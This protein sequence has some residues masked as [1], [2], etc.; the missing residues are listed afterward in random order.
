M[1]IVEL[2]DKLIDKIRNTK[3]DYV[4]EEVYRLLVLESES[5]QVYL[6]TS[7]ENRLIDISLKDIE[8]GNFL[9]N[10]EVNNQTEEWLN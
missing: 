5:E 7:E 2:Q 10:E 8:D 1:S 4:L 3:D 6:L 9:T